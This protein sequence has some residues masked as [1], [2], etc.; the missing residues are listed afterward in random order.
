MSTLENVSQN[1][2]DSIKFLEQQDIVDFDFEK[3]IKSYIYKNAQRLKKKHIK[4]LRNLIPENQHELLD[5]LDLLYEYK[6]HPRDKKIQSRIAQK[7]DTTDLKTLVRISSY[8]FG[9]NPI[10]ILL[11]RGHISSSTAQQL[12]QLVGKNKNLFDTVK[13]LGLSRIPHGKFVEVLLT[14]NANQVASVMNVLS[15]SL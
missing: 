12:S 6:Q 4:K 13:Q 11:D 10:Q 14:E 5:I 8:L 3:E 15:N 9:K 7:L 2:Q 1:M